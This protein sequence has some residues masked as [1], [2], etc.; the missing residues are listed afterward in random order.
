MRGKEGQH[1]H[2]NMS[3]LSLTVMKAEERL[4]GAEGRPVGQVKQCLYNEELILRIFSLLDLCAD[5]PQ[6]QTVLQKARF[7]GALAA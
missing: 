6:N 3:L 4:K 1:F 7:Y 2:S 5:S